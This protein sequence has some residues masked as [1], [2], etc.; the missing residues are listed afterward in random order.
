LSVILSDPF[1]DCAVFVHTIGDTGGTGQT[2]PQG[3]SGNTG[4][5][6]FTTFLRSTNLYIIRVI[7]R[8]HILSLCILC[9]F[10]DVK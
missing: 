1:T 3:P 9:T 7:L 5:T 10:Q 2:G 8:V 6:L 4:N